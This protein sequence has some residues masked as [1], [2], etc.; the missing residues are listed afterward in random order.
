MNISGITGLICSHPTFCAIRVAGCG[1]MPENTVASSGS[2]ADA[3]PWPN[4]PSRNQTNGT[5]SDTIPNTS[6]L[7]VLRSTARRGR[8]TPAGDWRTDQVA[9]HSVHPGQNRPRSK[10]TIPSRSVPARKARRRC[11]QKM[12]KVPKRKYN[13]LQLLLDSN[14]SGVLL[15]AMGNQP[16]TV[17]R[18]HIT[19]KDWNRMKRSRGMCS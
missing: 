8:D 12:P 13:G 9:V 11:W 19:V 18:G 3:G 14:N 5:P 7:V 15:P 1:L 4:S 6:V 16:L 17:K 2:G 10:P